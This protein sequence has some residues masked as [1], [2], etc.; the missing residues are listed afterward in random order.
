MFRCWGY[1]SGKLSGS[2]GGQGPQCDLDIQDKSAS[3]PV[4][5][6]VDTVAA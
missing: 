4:Q 6:Q 1:D 2:H 3:R 5:M